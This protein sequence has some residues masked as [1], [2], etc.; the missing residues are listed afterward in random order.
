MVRI[1]VPGA[2]R[3]EIRLER[4]GDDL[5]VTLGAHRRSVR[6]P[7][8]LHSASN[9]LQL[10]A[11]AS[12][13]LADSG[14]CVEAL[15]SAGVEEFLAHRRAEGYTLWLSAKAMV[16]M[17][18]YLRDLG[19]APIPTSAVPATEAAQLHEHYRAYLVEER[20]LAAGTI[21]GYLHVARLFFSARAAD[22][23]LRLERLTAGE[24]TEFVLAEC[25]T[26]SVGSA[27]DAS[28]MIS[29]NHPDAPA[30]DIAAS[31]GQP[32]PQTEVSI[33]S[34]G[35]DGREAN[36]IVPVG[37]VGEICVRRYG[38]MIAYND[39]PEA[40]SAAIDEQCRLHTGDLG[41][42]DS[43]G[44]LR[45][46]GRVKDMIIRGGENHFPA[47]IENALLQ[48]HTVA[49]VAVVGLPDPKWGEIIGAFVRTEEHAVLDIDALRGHCRSLLSPQK[50]P[51][52]WARVQ[53]F[54]LTGSG[55]VR[56]HVIRRSIRL[57]LISTAVATMEA[58]RDRP[59]REV[60]A[61]GP[62]FTPVPKSATP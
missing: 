31:A 36:E 28:P 14:L 6:L 7:D 50:T 45:I 25:S 4:L 52:I 16:P 10:M 8:T 13:W 19:V 33:R 37:T 9:Q 35:D 51:T 59:Y 21:A 17:L 22:S 1:P 42:L 23:E 32:L 40:T 48:H 54:P 57:D 20:G 62:S 61:G 60:G 47:E 15:S 27:T 26:R 2:E 55:K 29:L 49:E 39:N 30:E 3:G 44:F 24:V 18:D 43:R 56:K 12:R 5:V 34:T 53:E 41:T 46:T 38:V 58:R 11:H